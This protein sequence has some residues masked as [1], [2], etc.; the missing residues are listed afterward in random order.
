MVQTVADQMDQRIADV[1]DHGLID[2]GVLTGDRELG[3]FGQ[4]LGQI[5]NHAGKLAEQSFDGDHPRAEACPLQLIGH[6]TQPR[7]GLAI[8]SLSCSL[9]ACPEPRSRFSCARRF[10]SSTSSPTRSTD[11]RAYGHRLAWWQWSG[12]RRTPLPHSSRARR[13]GKSGTPA[14]SKTAA[15][16]AGTAIGAML[17]SSVIS[18]LVI[19]AFAGAGSC[20]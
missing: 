2:F 20:A 15:A 4:S 19:S 10:L 16:V 8:A 3:F 18:A 5:A 6:E 13:S 11:N 1:F 7:G 9:P 12:F 17:A 14:A